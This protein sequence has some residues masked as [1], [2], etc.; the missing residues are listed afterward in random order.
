MQIQ[1][2][3]G[4]TFNNYDDDLPPSVEFLSTTTT[5]AESAGRHYL[6]LTLSNQSGKNISVKLEVQ[7]IS[8]AKFGEDY[9]IK[10]GCKFSYR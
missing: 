10:S 3:Q 1:A 7:S 2:P 5:V 8:S 6:I 9:T 4:L